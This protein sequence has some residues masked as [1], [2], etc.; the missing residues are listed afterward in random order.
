[1][2]AA[3]TTTDQPTIPQPEWNSSA[4]TMRIWFNNLVRWLP[5]E[6]RAYRSLIE[7]GYYVNRDKAIASSIAQAVD[8]TDGNIDTYSFHD[9]APAVYQQNAA[10]YAAA[11]RRTN[12][13]AAAAA[14]AA[15]RTPPQPSN[16][17]S[18]PD[19]LPDSY[20]VTI[21]PSVIQAKRNDLCETILSTVPD[22]DKAEELRTACNGDG[23]SL[24]RLIHTESSKV[25]AKVSGAID[26]EM[27]NLLTTGLAEPTLA[28]F[29]RWK[30]EY[31][32]CGTSP[33]RRT[34][35]RTA[36]LQPDMPQ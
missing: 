12:E 33:T 31:K 5:K 3:A 26:R 28:C 17:P 9:P 16:T 32:S 6:D 14:A 7:R 10:A 13:A 18:F 25:S 11:V 19:R 23:C 1:M 24:L 8:I 36:S 2:A 35:C 22:N 30:R 4:L 34:C 20:A 27:Q 21:A 15:S 29:N